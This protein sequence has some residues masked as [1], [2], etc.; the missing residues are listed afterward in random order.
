M[1]LYPSLTPYDVGQTVRPNSIH[2]CQMQ[3]V[4]VDLAPG[5]AAGSKDIVWVA[6]VGKPLAVG[7]PET[8]VPV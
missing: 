8:A 6:S 4:L 1:H 5:A 3:L 7:F 2:L